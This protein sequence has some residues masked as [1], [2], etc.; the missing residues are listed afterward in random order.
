MESTRGH[1][2]LGGLLVG[3]GALLV[4]GLATF[5]VRAGDPL[6]LPIAKADPMTADGQREL[7]RS[8]GRKHT[9]S[10]LIFPEQ[11]IPIRFS[12]AK[13]VG[14][15]T[16]TQCHTSVS[17]SLRAKDRN[18]P[19]EAVCLDCHDQAAAA[20][21]EATDPPSSCDTCHPGFEPKWLPGADF[22]DTRAVEVHPPAVLLGE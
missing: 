4:L 2:S 7:E 19:A 21:G 6:P 8:F 5:A 1:V 12:H 15:V 22:T 11:T 20:R 3:A 18:L 9:P 14:L 17:T 16:C 10:D 13:H